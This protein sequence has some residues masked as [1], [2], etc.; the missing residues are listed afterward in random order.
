MYKNNN[1][2]HGIMNSFVASMLSLYGHFRSYVSECVK[3]NAILL[4][5]PR[6]WSTDMIRLKALCFRVTK[7][8]RRTMPSMENMLPF[9]LRKQTKEED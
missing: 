4:E 2:D 3:E 1:S 5:P 9:I 7:L 6:K 8:P